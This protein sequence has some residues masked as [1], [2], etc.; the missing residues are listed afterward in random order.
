MTV[1]AGHGKVTSSNC[2]TWHR[3]SETQEHQQ[4]ST[5]AHVHPSTQ[6]SPTQCRVS[7]RACQSARGARAHKCE[8]TCA[9]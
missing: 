3:A 9:K 7:A 5:R 4:A 6:T 1:T 8:E 2:C